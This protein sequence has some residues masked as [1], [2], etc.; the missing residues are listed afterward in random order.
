MLMLALGCPF[1]WQPAGWPK[2]FFMT[3]LYGLDYTFPLCFGSKSTIHSIPNLSL[4]IPK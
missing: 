2:A 1:T 3:E 4:N